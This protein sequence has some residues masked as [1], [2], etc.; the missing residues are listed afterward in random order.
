[1]RQDV[2]HAI[3]IELIQTNQK[4]SNSRK[5]SESVEKGCVECG[6]ELIGKKIYI[7]NP[8]YHMISEYNQ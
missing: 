4:E 7:M 1:M 2:D 5:S 6:Q 8:I 3:E